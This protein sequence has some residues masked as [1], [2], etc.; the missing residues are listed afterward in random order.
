MGGC[1]SIF[2]GS[3]VDE[4]ELPTVYQ[5]WN[6][7]EYRVHSSWTKSFVFSTCYHHSLCFFRPI[8]FTKNGQILGLTNYNITLLRLNDKGGLFEHH[9]KRSVLFCFEIENR[10]I[11]LQI[12][13]NSSQLL[14]TTSLFLNQDIIRQILVLCC[15]PV[16]ILR[17]RVTFLWV[18]K[19]KH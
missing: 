10:N 2:V 16:K 17:C 1:L 12:I 15:Y 19:V 4:Y 18:Q 14:N 7:K 9:G 8:Y 11:L 13:N 5:M 3:H 6:M